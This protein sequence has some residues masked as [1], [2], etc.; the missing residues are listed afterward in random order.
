MSPVKKGELDGIFAATTLSSTALDM[1]ISD[2]V[3]ARSSIHYRETTGRMGQNKKPE[4][5]NSGCLDD[6]INL[7][8]RLH[9]V[10]H[11][12]RNATNV[13]PKDTHYSLIYNGNVF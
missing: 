12:G 9:W 13:D 6:R 11:Y 8:W 4:K 3:S 5:H 2:Q 7:E 1:Q 10:V